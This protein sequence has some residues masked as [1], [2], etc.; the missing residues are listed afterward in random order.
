MLEILLESNMSNKII[1]LGAHPD[2]IEIGC[3]GTIKKFV[4]QNAEVYFIIATLGGKVTLKNNDWKS[5]EDE[6]VKESLNAAKFLG[7]KEVFFLNL[8]DTYIEHNGKTISA[9]EKYLN[10]IDPDLVF[11]H[12]KEDHH[13]DHKNLA[14]STISA[15]RRQKANIL[16]YETP[17]T[18]QTFLPTIYSDI[19]DTIE[20]KIKAIK[21]F[22]SQDEKIY[23][24]PDAIKGLA[25]YRGY[26]SGSKY[27]EGFD[28]SKYYL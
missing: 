23:V 22:A 14:F 27:A 9:I 2:D 26:T 4:L 16:H 3:G 20:L 17:S 24:N 28:V 25:K 11:T 1:C 10:I 5:I 6:R 15:C 21:L 18:A 19:S 12:T 13:Q 7:V 8:P